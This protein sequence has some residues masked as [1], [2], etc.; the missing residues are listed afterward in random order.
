MTHQKTVKTGCLRILVA[1]LLCA[2]VSICVGDDPEREQAATADN[3]SIAPNQSVSIDH[4]DPGNRAAESGSPAPDVKEQDTDRPAGSHR[5]KSFA[6]SRAVEQGAAGRRVSHG[7]SR[8]GPRGLSPV[9][10]R[11]EGLVSGP[12]YRTGF[13]ALAI[14]LVTIGM[15]VW[16][17]RRFLPLTRSS[18]SG[19]LRVVAR[20]SLSPKHSVALMSVGRRFVLIGLSGDRI[21]Q[22]CQVTDPEEVAELAARTGAAR[23]PSGEDFDTLLVQEAEDYH[24]ALGE[25]EKP[26]G[27]FTNRKRMQPRGQLGALLG[28]LRKLQT[29]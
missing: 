24:S 21:T 22:V 1:F 25:G 16:L 8:I 28:K 7:A 14:V 3:R 29:R 11:P 9:L 12:W 5:A 19:V 17:A 26:R 6:A 27:R 4:A 18:E 23:T 20:A 2:P 15:V 10:G 13:G